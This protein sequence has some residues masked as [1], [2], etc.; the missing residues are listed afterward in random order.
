MEDLRRVSGLLTSIDAGLRTS[1]LAG[2]D[3][4]R[5]CICDIAPLLDRL[6]NM[7]CPWGASAMRA[8]GQLQ[9]AL[10]RT[11]RVLRDGAA[12]GDCNEGDCELLGALRQLWQRQIEMNLAVQFQNVLDED[13]SRS[14][15]G[16]CGDS[17]M[18]PGGLSGLIGEKIGL[19]QPMV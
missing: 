13:S 6:K 11:D 7:A 18:Q 4:L 14:A 16:L 9:A 5:R 10:E 12:S 3:R 8:L 1:E 19:K 17:E 15:K 2:C